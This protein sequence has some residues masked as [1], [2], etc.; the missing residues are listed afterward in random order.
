MKK[1][2]TPGAIFLWNGKLHEAVGY[3]DRKVIFH[4]PVN[5][6][7]CEHCGR[8]ESHAEVEG[9]PTFQEAVRP[10]DTLTED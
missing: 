4:R 8:V 2:T 6:L 1:L 7:P 5:A 9:S 10:V 3:T